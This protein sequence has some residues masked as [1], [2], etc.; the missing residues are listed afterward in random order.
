V[1]SPVPA[2]PEAAPAVARVRCDACGPRVVALS[3]VR[4]VG[5]GRRWQYLFTCPG[6]GTR[7]RRTADE[8]LRSA[9]RGVGA[10]EL[11]L[12]DTR[13]TPEP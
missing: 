8:A 6:C 12:L 4:L 11:S 2:T 13:T 5:F 1:S 3:S 9:L 7:V 10:S